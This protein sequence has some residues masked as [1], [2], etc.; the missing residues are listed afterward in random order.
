MPIAKAWS[1]PVKVMAGRFTSEKASIMVWTQGGL[2]L[3]LPS[4]AY[5]LSDLRHYTS[6][7]SFSSEKPELPCLRL[8]VIMRIKWDDMQEN[9]SLTLKPY[10]N[11]KNV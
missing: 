3:S 11:T 9:A 6:E 8:G 2:V 7:S 1:K 5:Q 10:I 4:T